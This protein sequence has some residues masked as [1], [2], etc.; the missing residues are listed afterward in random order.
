MTTQSSVD[1]A[2]KKQGAAADGFRVRLMSDAPGIVEMAA[3]P[4]AIVSVHVGPP[5]RMLCRH[6]D[7]RQS[8]VA[9]HGDVEIIPWGMSGSW[10][11]QQRDT[12]L[13][14]SLSPA[15]FRR[16]AEESGF[17]SSGLELSSRFHVRDLSIEYIA[18][19]LKNEMENG[20]PC[21]RLYHDSLATA[22]ALHLLHHHSSHNG[23]QNNSM[24]L[25]LNAPSGRMPS[26][27]LKD[28][29]RFIDEHL[30]EDL[31]L[32]RIARV[33]GVSGSHLN[34]L[35]GAAVGYS[36][37]QYVIRR[38]V[39][40]AA[41]LLEESRLPVSQIALETGFAHQSHLALHMRRIMGTTPR[42][43]RTR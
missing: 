2:R 34:V 27:K 38:R 18:W 37:H 4:N 19:A 7:Q 3:L 41:W 29:L 30:G 39:D 8:G 12:A 1:P 22:L 32:G 23:S 33:A 43:L 35:F 9:I 16:S 40:R 36:I 15:L 28:V 25:R 14:M 5:T 42:K 13:V 21:G 31:S 6:G 10:E 24:A 11:L 20:H 26:R 17:D